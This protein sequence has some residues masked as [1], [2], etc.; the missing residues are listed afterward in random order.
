MWFAGFTRAAGTTPA[1]WQ[2]SKHKAHSQS[3]PGWQQAGS[4]LPP[5][6]G[7]CQTNSSWITENP[8]NT[9]NMDGPL[10]PSVTREAILSL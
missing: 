2:I 8:E 1:R 9:E 7:K 3:P 10:A 6:G 4:R 5:A